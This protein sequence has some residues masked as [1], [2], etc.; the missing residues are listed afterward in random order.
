MGSARSRRTTCDY[1]CN[2]DTFGS[3]EAACVPIKIKVPRVKT[4][5]VPVRVPGNKKT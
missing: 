3:C 4:V 5:A 2:S 1:C